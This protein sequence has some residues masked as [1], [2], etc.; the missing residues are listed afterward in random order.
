MN[1]SFFDLD[2]T[3]LNVNSSSCFG[4]YLYQEGVFSTKLY[5]HLGT[6]Y[7]LFKMGVLSLLEMQTQIFQKLFRGKPKAFF[8]T[9]A[10][11]FLDQNFER[12]LYLP[13]VKRLKQALANGELVVIL[14]SSP[15]FLV[16]LIAERLNVVHWQ[17]SIYAIDSLGCFSHLEKLLQGS[18]KANW[19]IKFSKQ[20][21]LSK[22]NTTVF[23]D[24]ILDLPFLKSGGIKIGVNPDRK[25]RV[26]CHQNHWEIL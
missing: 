15:D 24:S 5:I 17:A 9:H 10:H 2:G 4:R 12:F 25:L 3:L 14:S 18:D 21:N 16:K 11:S 7:L 13:A 8:E 23:S 26:L 20:R 1:A 19:V 22:C 6:I